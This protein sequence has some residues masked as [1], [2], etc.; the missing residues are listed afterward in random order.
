MPG[1]CQVRGN[2]VW[3]TTGG[4]DVNL[5][6]IRIR[7]AERRVCAVSTYCSAKGCNRMVCTPSG[8]KLCGM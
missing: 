3:R 1:T 5:M 6:V 7:Q 2:E 8:V 4:V